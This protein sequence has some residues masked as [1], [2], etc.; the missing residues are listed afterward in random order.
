MPQGEDNRPILARL[1]Q[2]LESLKGHSLEQR[3]ATARSEHQL[4]GIV[5]DVGANRIAYLSIRWIFSG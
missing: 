3:F 1:C 5:A 2:G 4:F